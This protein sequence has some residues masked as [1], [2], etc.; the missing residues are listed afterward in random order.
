LR[1]SEIIKQEGLFA[2]QRC[3]A[4]QISDRT[5]NRTLVALFGK[6]EGQKKYKKKR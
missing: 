6:T 5:D 4:G 3:G 2:A 1:S